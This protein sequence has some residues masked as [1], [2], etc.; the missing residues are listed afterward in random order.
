MT[1]CRLEGVNPLIGRLVRTKRG[2]AYILV[3]EP[4]S[5]EYDYGSGELAVENVCLRIHMA[6]SFSF[7]F[8]GDDIEHDVNEEGTATEHAQFPENHDP[9]LQ[10]QLHAMK[11]LV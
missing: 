5:V 8:G 4:G 3:Y 11:D 7:G 9:V 6:R 2:L 1:A 10:P